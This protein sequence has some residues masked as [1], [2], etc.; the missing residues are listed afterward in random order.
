MMREPVFAARTAEEEDSVESTLQEMNIA[1]DR[2]LDARDTGAVCHLC[3]FYDVDGEE[4][5][6]SR[7]ALREA[8]LAAGVVEVG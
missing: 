8:G 2:R 3:T 7:R 6:R 1:F 4:A 5:A